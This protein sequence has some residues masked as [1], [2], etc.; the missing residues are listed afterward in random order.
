[1]EAE[2]NILMVYTMFWV[3]M[4]RTTLPVTLADIVIEIISLKAVKK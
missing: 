3:N 1:M 4:S 2:I